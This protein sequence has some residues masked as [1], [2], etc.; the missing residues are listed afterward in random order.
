[1]MQDNLK[2]YGDYLYHIKNEKYKGKECLVVQAGESRNETY[3]VDA[4]MGFI[5]KY[6]ATDGTKSEFSFE[7]DN[8]T[9][10]EVKAPMASLLQIKNNS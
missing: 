1:M 10:D 8:V 6:E 2:D 5:L 4:Q 9:D 7:I 3:W